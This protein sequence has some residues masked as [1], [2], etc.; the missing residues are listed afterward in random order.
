M[1]GRR[2]SESRMT[3]TQPM[4]VDMANVLGNVHGGIIMRLC[5]EAG[6]YA[7]MKHSRRPVVTVAVDSMS[8]HSAVNIGNLLTVHAEVTWVG[9]TSM[10]T[11]ILVTAEELM[12]SRVTHTNTAY[13]VYVALDERG[14]PADV[15]P[16]LLE[17]DE[18]RQLFEEGAQRQ[19]RRLERRGR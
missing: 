2:V 16:L 7:A 4:G 10:E 14:R 9:R 12:S 17:T 13:F 18:E 6:A 3:F 19:A 5:D 11:R 8:F 15:P 1:N